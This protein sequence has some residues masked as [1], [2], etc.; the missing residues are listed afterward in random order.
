[1]RIG[2]IF[3]AIDEDDVLIVMSDHGI[4]SHMAHDRRSV[5]LAG[6]GQ[7]PSGHGSTYFPLW[8]IPR[9]LAALL[10]VPVD[11][12]QSGVGGWIEHLKPPPPAEAP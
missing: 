11:W 12:A 7:V 8:G 10:D 1:M 2:Q 9:M 3:N 6:G 4:S 5:F